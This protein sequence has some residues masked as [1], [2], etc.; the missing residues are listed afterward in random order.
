MAW[1]QEHFPKPLSVVIRD[2][3]GAFAHTAWVTCISGKTPLMLN[4]IGFRTTYAAIKTRQCIT[5][6]WLYSRRVCI[7]N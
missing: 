2:G 4:D 3:I 6:A 5:I 1:A 7:L